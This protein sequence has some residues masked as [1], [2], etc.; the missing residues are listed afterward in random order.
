[1]TNAPLASIA[2]CRDIESLNLYHVATT[3]RGMDPAQVMAAIRIKGRDN[4]RTPMQWSAGAHAGFTSG[5]PWIAVNPNHAAVN[6]AQALAD[7]DS[8]FH[9]YRRLIELRREHAVIVHGCYEQLLP[10]H[11]QIDAYTRTLGRQVLLVV[12]NFSGDTPC[13]E[14]PAGLPVEGARLLITNHPVDPAA[15]LRSFE[16]RPWEARVYLLDNRQGGTS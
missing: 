16:L 8:V 13:F 9:H 3:E 15:G 10:D 5:T 11:P 1:M 2:D 4:A 6:A 12:C 7:P 14:W